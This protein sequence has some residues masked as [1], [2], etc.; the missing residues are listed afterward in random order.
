[1]IKT[2]DFYMAK[3]YALNFMGFCVVLLCL[4][5][6]FEAI[7][8]LRRA[9]G[10]EIALSTIF[11][12]A[13]LK[14]PEVGQD[15]ML[16]AIFFAALFTF[17][18]LNKTAQLVIIRGAGLSVWRF[19]L[20][21]VMTALCLTLLK[22][23]VV[24]PLG[25]LM[26]SR[27]IVLENRLLK[28]ESETVS[29]SE[30]GLWLRQNLGGGQTAFLHADQID[31]RDWI[32]SHPEIIILNKTGGFEQR[33]AAPSARLEDNSWILNN[34]S[35]ETARG[36]Y[37]TGTR[38]VFTSLSSAR[39]LERSFNAPAMQSFW[40]FP[41]YIRTLKRTGLNAA[42][43]E[44]FFQKLMAQPL[45][46]LAFILMAAAVTLQPARLQFGLKLVAAGVTIGL[47]L[48]FFINYFGAL[49]ASDQI[50]VLI[51]VWFPPLIAFLGGAGA[52]LMLED[53]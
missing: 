24:N 31:T 45:L 35:S 26:Q 42:P 47:L 44:V 3:K 18:Q 46:S 12:M 10:K 52:L 14:L 32:L 1:M 9:E 20:P 15:M 11:G 40:A 30:Q 50:P 48:F 13:F 16:F 51:A 39:E 17:W 38:F 33:I 41:S 25:A 29:L 19:V 22:I 53:G 4:I 27:F 34:A 49:G 43:A 8:L 37:Q 23:M 5:Y 6:I 36:D 7:E 28:Q 2:L 21:L